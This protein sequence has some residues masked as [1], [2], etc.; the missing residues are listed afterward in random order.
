MSQQSQVG[1]ATTT[2]HTGHPT[3]R[4]YFAVAMVLSGL[5]AVEV[6]VFYFNW[7]GYGIIPVLAV[8]SIGKFAL[9]AMFYMHLKYDARLYTVL[10][11]TGVLLATAVLLAVLALFK[12]FV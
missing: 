1:A 7:L 11:V 2:A 6:V 3:P 5:T 8:L 12:F 9:V 10:F 4:T